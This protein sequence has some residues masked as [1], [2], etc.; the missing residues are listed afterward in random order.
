MKPWFSIIIALS[1][2]ACSGEENHPK[3]YYKENHEARKEVLAWCDDNPGE[4]P[5]PN[6]VNAEAATRELRSEL[7]VARATERR[8]LEIDLQAVNWIGKCIGPE[9]IQACRAGF[10]EKAAPLRAALKDFNDETQTM[11]NALRY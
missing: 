8:S 1:L 4:A 7:T 11:I 10:E 9:D 5:L 2:T 3:N 6:C